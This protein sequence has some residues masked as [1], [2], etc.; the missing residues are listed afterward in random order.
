MVDTIP[1]GNG[2]FAEVPGVGHGLHNEDMD[3][4]V[5]IIRGFLDGGQ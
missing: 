2:T 3:A 5:D 4:T 1:N